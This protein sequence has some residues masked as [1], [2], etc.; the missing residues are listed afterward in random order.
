MCERLRIHPNGLHS[1]VGTKPLGV[2]LELAPGGIEGIAHRLVGVLV[3]GPL[4]VLALHHDVPAGDV[5]VQADVE[6]PTLL[7]MPVRL[8]HHYLGSP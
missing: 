4:A 2:V 1:T 8:L 7:M 3:R 5:Q 6:M